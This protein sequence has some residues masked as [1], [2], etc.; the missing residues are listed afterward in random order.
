MRDRT[1]LV[2]SLVAGAAVGGAV[3][4]LFLTDDG[5][6]LRQNLRPHLEDLADRAVHLRDTAMRAQRLA[7]DS[8]RTI[9]EVA[10]R[11]AT[12]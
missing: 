2:V 11:P 10:A 8:W 12:R 3:G 5:R 6:R 7:H 9:Q 4:W 1:A